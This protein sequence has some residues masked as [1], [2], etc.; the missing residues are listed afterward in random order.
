MLNSKRYIIY[1]LSAFILTLL[2]NGCTNLSTDPSN[3]DQNNIKFEIISPLS[4]SNVGLGWLEIK[5]NLDP[6]FSLKFIELYINNRFEKNFSPKPNGLPPDI[7]VFI[8]SVLLNSKISYYLVYYDTRGFSIKSQEQKEL[9]VVNTT[10]VPYAPFKLEVTR[11]SPTIINLSWKDTS[12]YVDSY[13]I[14]KKEG[15]NGT[16][17][18][19]KTVDRNTFN[20]NDDDASQVKDFYYK[21]RSLN[22]IGYSN[23]STEISSNGTGSS[24]SLIPPT[25]L[26]ATALGTQV[27]YLKWSDNSADE[28]L[29]KIERRT[30]WTEYKVVGVT[31]PN[32]SE[33]TDS[34]NGLQRG[35]TYIYRVK[36]F[37]G[38]DSA[39]SNES[40]AQT[41]WYDLIIP[42]NL[43]A[44]FNSAE[45]V[46]LNW[47]DEDFA[48]THFEIERKFENGE[49]LF[50]AMIPGDVNTYKDSLVQQQHFYS[51]RVRATDGQYYSR[52]S[53]V[54]VVF[55]GN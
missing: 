28:N 22:S 34:A 32:I 5:Y 19:L 51:Y 35:E 23:F 45:G 14:W 9:L 29:F 54:A 30:V 12:A 42:K 40:S 26:T 27:V 24:G 46:I 21:V 52:Y 55:T 39:W 6:S 43:T 17:N 18:L 7:K 47:I 49:F 15:F 25:G 50:Y 36:A 20:S 2:L 33:F 8:D 3:P 38:S 44:S 41:F 37:S 31:G 11:L 53:N 13:E 10:T 4:N 1:I 48:N 16:Y